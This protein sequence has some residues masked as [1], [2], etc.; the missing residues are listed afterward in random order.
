MNFKCIFGHS[1]ETKDSIEVKLDDFSNAVY[2]VKTQNCT[3]CPKIKVIET[4]KLLSSILEYRI[5][6]YVTDNKLNYRVSEKSTK[7][8]IN[9]FNKSLAEIR[10]QEKERKEFDDSI[11]RIQLQILQAYI[12][13][14]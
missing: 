7:V 1:F 6:K 10:D 11:N 2:K 5:A 9:E 13:L 4:E 8:S 12:N 14:L 3:I